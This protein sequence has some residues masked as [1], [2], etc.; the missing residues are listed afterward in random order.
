MSL[1]GVIQDS[2]IP[3]LR[4]DLGYVYISYELAKRRY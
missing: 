3:E 1:S 4:Q 2:I